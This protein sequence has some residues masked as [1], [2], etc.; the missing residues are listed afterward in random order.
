MTPLLYFI[1]LF[2]LTGCSGDS[3]PVIPHTPIDERIRMLE[4]KINKLEKEIMR[5]DVASQGQ[6]F[7]EWHKYAKTLEEIEK[8]EHQLEIWRNQLDA[9][10][11]K[12][13]RR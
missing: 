6:M 4:E 1:C 12:R 8:E 9:L 2:F 5:K 3:P 7:E 10:K 13:A 11:K